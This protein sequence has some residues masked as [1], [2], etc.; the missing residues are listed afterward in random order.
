MKLNLQQKINKRRNELLKG[1]W[2]IQWVNGWSNESRWMNE[3]V[4]ECIYFICIYIYIFIY[5]TDWKTNDEWTN[6]R[7]F[8]SNHAVMTAAS[9]LKSNAKG[10]GLGHGPAPLI[11]LRWP[12]RKVQQDASISGPPCCCSSTYHMTYPNIPNINLVA[13]AVF[14]NQLSTSN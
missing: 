5:M 4:N 6:E 13:L 7:P 3:W 12:M 14:V 9:L 11:D 10:T 1:K 2:I 8:V